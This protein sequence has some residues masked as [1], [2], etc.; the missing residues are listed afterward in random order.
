MNNVSDGLVRTDGRGY[1]TVRLPR[2]FQA[3]N[4]RFRYQLTTIRSF[5]RAVVW[6]EV[7]HNRFVIRTARPRVRVSWQVT[8]R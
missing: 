7:R 5:A 3:P 8:G 2:R 4:Q 1:A 6:R